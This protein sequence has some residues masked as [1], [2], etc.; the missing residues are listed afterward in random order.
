MGKEHTNNFECGICNYKS[1][2]K[3]DLE[4]H[5]FTCEIYKCDKCIS[6]IKKHKEKQHGISANN[7][8]HHVKMDRNNLIEVCDFF[9]VD[10]V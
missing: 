7:N 8:L 5:L 10:E 2:S 9:V 4:V 3:E 6:K 1:Q